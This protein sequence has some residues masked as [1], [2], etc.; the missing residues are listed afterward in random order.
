MSNRRCGIGDFFELALGDQG[1]VRFGG[2][3]QLK[4]SATV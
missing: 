1:D 4:L 3:A 2:H